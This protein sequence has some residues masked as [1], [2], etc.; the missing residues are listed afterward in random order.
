MPNVLPTS[1]TAPNTIAGTITMRESALRWVAAACVVL[2]VL[3]L[4]ASNLPPGLGPPADPL[5]TPSDLRPPWPMLAWY[6]LVD[7]APAGFPVP[8]L[9]V[10][11]CALLL[12][13]PFLARRLADRRPGIHAAVGAAAILAG[14]ALALLGLLR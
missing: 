9:V 3:V 14:G 5:H 4:A 1:M 10:A 13:W 6:A 2:G 12:L 7:R 11:A 8:I